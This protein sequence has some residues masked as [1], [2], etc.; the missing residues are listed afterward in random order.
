[1]T[2][3]QTNAKGLLNKAQSVKAT[4]AVLSG[5]RYATLVALIV[6]VIKYPSAVLVCVS[7]FIALFVIG[8]I[9]KVVL[10]KTNKEIVLLSA[11]KDELEFYP[12]NVFLL[13]KSIIREAIVWLHV[14][15]AFTS[16]VFLST[17]IFSPLPIGVFV[18]SVATMVCCAIATDQI[19]RRLNGLYTHVYQRLNSTKQEVVL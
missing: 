13:R 9:K 15:V 7:L 17:S 6:S 1:M 3:E 4:I 19:K 8:S 5:L 18:V 14:L 10:F 11:T 16:A 2:N 12:T